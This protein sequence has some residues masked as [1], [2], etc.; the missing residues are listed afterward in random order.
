MKPYGSATAD[1]LLVDQV[2]ARA[3]RDAD[4]WIERLDDMQGQQTVQDARRR[5]ESMDLEHAL[6]QLDAIAYPPLSTEL[7]DL[8]PSQRWAKSDAEMKVEARYE[9]GQR[10]RQ[11]ICVGSLQMLQRAK[12]ATHFWEL[13]G[14]HPRDAEDDPDAQDL[15]MAWS[16][17]SRWKAYATLAKRSAGHKGSAWFALMAKAYRLMTVQFLVRVPLNGSCAPD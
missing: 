5:A 12:G 15:Q 3:L 11:L 4:Y 13:L 9:A 1:Q 8:D 16:C 17:F 7:D 2:T 10:G 6:E 14:I